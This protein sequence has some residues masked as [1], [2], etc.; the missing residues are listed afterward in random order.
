MVGGSSEEGLIELEWDKFDASKTAPAAA[1]VFPPAVDLLSPPLG[2][3]EGV[4][5][6]VDGE[7]SGN[8][9]T[10]QDKDDENDDNDGPPPR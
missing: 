5:K 6:P 1:V 2:G 9:P 10:V 3:V 8:T 4:L 7:G